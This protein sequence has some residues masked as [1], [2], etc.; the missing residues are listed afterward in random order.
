MEVNFGG[1]FGGSP[2]NRLN[3]NRED[4]NFIR[5]C[6]EAENIRVMVVNS[7]KQ[8]LTQTDDQI[9]VAW[10]GRNGVKE[11]GGDLS[12]ITTLLLGS[13]DEV[14]YFAVRVKDVLENAS[15]LG[16]FRNLRSLLTSLGD[17]DA[18]IAAQAVSL[19]FFHDRHRFCGSCGAPTVPELGGG[20]LRCCRNS[21][22]ENTAVLHGS[23]KDGH[24]DG[25]CSGMW[26]PRIDCVSIML[27][28]DSSGERCLLGR[29]ERFP[30]AMWSCLAGFMEHGE[31]VEDSARR[32]VAEESGVVVGPKVR[33]FGCQPWPQPYSLMLGCV[34]QSQADGEDISVDEKEL[35]DTRWFSRDEVSAM[36]ENTIASE[37]KSRDTGRDQ[38]TKKVLSD[39]PMD[40]F[41]PPSQAIAG[42][43][44][45][46]FA[47]RDPVTVF[48]SSRM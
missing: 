34:M 27:V 45:A 19:C 15:R 8:V 9:K 47:R 18:A 28:V 26:H 40:C 13:L 17:A 48:S 10:L 3:N 21:L 5:R 2:L 25:S 1:I 24:A 46:A 37:A 23:G 38:E 7:Q 31:R 39:S 35:E 22:G 36:V 14:Y 33:Y 6:A 44:L 12:N 4:P 20:R 30:P 16:S 29:Q 32:E 41:V 43:M 11:V 42:A